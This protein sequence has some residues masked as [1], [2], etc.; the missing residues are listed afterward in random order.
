MATLTVTLIEGRGLVAMD[1]NGFSDPYVVL[2][3]GEHRKRSKIMY[4]TLEPVWNEV[5]ELALPDPPP[6]LLHLRLWDKDK[7]GK[8]D[9]M[10]VVCAIRLT[11]A[12]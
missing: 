10:G 1:R 11:S 7:V 6:P 9:R 2:D 5:F 4:K 8:D 3:I 12:V